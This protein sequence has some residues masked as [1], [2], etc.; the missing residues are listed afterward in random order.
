LIE[1]FGGAATPGI[2]FA[3]GLE[4]LLM[5]IAAQGVV[6]DT[7]AP[8]AVYIANIG[9]KQARLAAGICL[10]LRERGIKAEADLMDRN[11]KAQMKYAGKIGAAYV[12]VLGEEEAASGKAKLRDMRDG[13]ER[14]IVLDDP[15]I[16]A[17]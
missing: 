9:Q 10:K 6:I 13:T 2:G 12:I 14:E 8:T 11:L 1:E 15:D 16:M 3:L 4:R 17:I 7:P 5:E